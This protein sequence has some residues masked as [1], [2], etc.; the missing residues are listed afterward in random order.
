MLDTVDP[1]RT[2]T[3]VPASSSEYRLSDLCRSHS[4]SV[5]ASS[6]EG[7]QLADCREALRRRGVALRLSKHVNTPGPPAMVNTRDSC[8]GKHQG[9]QRLG[10][11]KVTLRTATSRLD[12]VRQ[13]CKF[14]MRTLD[15]K[16]AASYPEMLHTWLGE[17]IWVTTASGRLYPSEPTHTLLL[18]TDCEA[19][20]FSGCPTLTS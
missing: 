3:R 7:K 6:V 2:G 8:D 13:S 15:Y 1:R 14:V 4:M 19:S 18:L 12:R 10:C 17:V 9:L 11:R 16:C 20:L 5:G